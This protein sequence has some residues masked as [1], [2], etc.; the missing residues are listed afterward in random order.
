MPKKT[1][2]VCCLV[3]LAFSV[4]GQE[5]FQEWEKAQKEKYTAFRCRKDEHFQRFLQKGW[6][7]FQIKAGLLEY[8]APKPDAIPEVPI[9]AESREEEP[10]TH[11]SEEEKSSRIKATIAAVL[12]V[13]AAGDIS[14][15]P[16]PLFLFPDIESPLKEPIPVDIIGHEVTFLIDPEWRD[17]FLQKQGE[18]GIRIF[19]EEFSRLDSRPIT[20]QLDACVER[21]A[22]GD[23]GRL[24]LTNRLAEAVAGRRAGENISRLLA[25]GWLL[26]GGF[27]VRVAR[28]GGG[29]VLLYTSCQKIFQTRYLN[30]RGKRYYV[31]GETGASRIST[32]RGGYEG[33]EKS[34]DLRQSGR[35]LAGGPREERKLRFRFENRDYDITVFLQTERIHF[36]K[37]VP[38]IPLC[39]YLEAG[40]GEAVRDSLISQL[41]EVISEMGQEQAVNFLL[42]FTQKA[43]AYRKDSEQFGQEK[44]LYP[45]ETLY[46]P[47][48]DCDDRVIF[49]S[50]M[51]RDLLGL[52][53]AIL[54]YTGHVA[55]ALALEQTVK[56]ACLSVDGR[57][58]TVADPT[59]INA[60]VGMIM[61]DYAEEEPRI[62]PL[63]KSC[64]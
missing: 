39:F 51:V 26:K 50:A 25:W 49:F 4:M 48:S 8:D 11:I 61:P 9:P 32:Y 42:R 3:L 59:Y 2:T 38:Q 28:A 53:I 18:E 37:M 47:A 16:V 63:W 58:L 33:A 55:T 10:G 23:W 30:I 27:D 57:T 12:P 45:E 6:K 35:L 14:E 36:L 13:E 29:V 64:S 17:L 20:A 15:G 34:L 46:Y 60:G 31:F 22:L 44:Y 54:R 1:I 62:L 41:R 7:E 43:F 56:G 24:V 19:W 5:D 40:P 21:L 52:D